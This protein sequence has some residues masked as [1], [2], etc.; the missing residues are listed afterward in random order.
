[1]IVPLRGFQGSSVPIHESDNASL[2]VADARSAPVGIG[3]SYVHT[4][5]AARVIQDP[6]LRFLLRFWSDTF[7]WVFAI[8]S[9]RSGVSQINREGRADHLRLLDRLQKPSTGRKATTPNLKI[10]TVAG[11]SV[12]NGKDVT[13]IEFFRRPFLGGAQKNVCALQVRLN[14]VKPGDTRTAVSGLRVTA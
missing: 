13:V 8:D 10:D 1:M 12:V 4:P 5:E 14:V 9:H 6:G 11:N 7:R 3:A 2:R